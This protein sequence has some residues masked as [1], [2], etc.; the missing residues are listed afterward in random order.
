M[1]MANKRIL[2]SLFNKGCEDVKVDV[3]SKQ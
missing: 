3:V 1:V 2:F